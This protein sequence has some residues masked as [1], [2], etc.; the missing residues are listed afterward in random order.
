LIKSYELSLATYNALIP[1]NWVISL[2]K[3]S[4]CKQV[5]IFKLLTNILGLVSL[6]FV[7]ILSI[8]DKMDLFLFY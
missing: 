1:I 8:E 7:N 5:N 3:F 4:M 2:S 6:K